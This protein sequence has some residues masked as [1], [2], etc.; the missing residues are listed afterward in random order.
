MA[1]SGLKYIPPAF[2]LPQE[3]EAFLKY[4]ETHPEKMFV[5]K[6]NDH[7]NIYV[8]NIKDI[9]L[10]SNSTFVQEFVHKPL[11]VSGH[12]FDIGIYVIITSVDP[13]R[14]YMYNG[15]V[16]LR[17]CPIK[18][19][20]FDEKNID[21]YV[22]GDDYLPIWKVPALDYYYNELG[23]GMKETINEYLRK[24]GKDPSIL[25]SQIEESI[26]LTLLAKEESITRS[27]NRFKFKQNLFEMMRFDFVADENLNIFLLE[28]NMSPNLSSAHFAPNELLYRQVLYNLFGLLGIGERIHKNSLARRS[29]VE[30]D[31]LVSDKNIAVYAEEC[32]SIKCKESCV[33]I[34][35]QLCKPCLSFDSKNYI[36]NAYKEH[37]NKGDCKRIFPPSSGNSLEDIK[38]ENYSPENQLHIRWFQG[39]CKMDKSWC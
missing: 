31:M 17:F 3:K 33:P 32:A 18:Y 5:E 10:N 23:F 34:I 2:K 25:W 15:D 36:I 16:L 11:L 21:K 20:P 19:Y 4:A 9:N 13:L 28:A 8:K 1:T 38:L 29:R 26:K 35:C 37:L 27:V 14:V 12:K 24:K 7:R 30:E 39:K 6:N 22:V